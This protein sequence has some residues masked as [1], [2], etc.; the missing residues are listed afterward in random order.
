MNLEMPMR[1]A[2]VGVILAILVVASL[3]IGYLAVS[4]STLTAASSPTRTSP[5]TYQTVT[6]STILSS[7]S[8][9]FANGT[10]ITEWITSVSTSTFTATWSQGQPIPVTM[11]ETDN[12]SVPDGSLLFNPTTDRMYILGTSSLTVVDASSHSVVATVPLPENNTGG[13]AN[14]GLAIDPSTDMVYATT[15]GEVVEV[16]GSTNTV[17]GALPLSLG[18]LAFD[19]ATGMLWGTEQGHRT[20]VEVDVRTGS[21]VANVSIGFP[22]YEVT[23]DPK[24]GLVYAEGCNI[25]G[26]VCLPGEAIVDGAT[27]AI[28][29]TLQLGSP[30]DITLDPATHVVYVAGEQ[31]LAAFSGTGKMIFDVNPQTCGPFTDMVVDPSANLVCMTPENSNYL[32]AYDGATGK[33]VN[34]YVFENPVG[35]AFFNPNTGELYVQDTAGHLIALRPLSS[36]GNVDT[37][38]IAPPQPGSCP[39]P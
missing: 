19:P 25:M 15:Q 36:T 28:V 13:S 10:A 22:P 21:V 27:G 9:T 5:F 3:G 11:V 30:P 35:L 17:V 31:Q 20:L 24:T 37:S 34:M 32:L 7:N 29:A 16:N 4:S 23:V 39:L 38:L 14:A 26:L 33:L 12:F 8:T 1:N 18:T 6:S 2:A